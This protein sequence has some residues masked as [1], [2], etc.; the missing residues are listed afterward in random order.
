[1]SRAG[2][3]RGES[4]TWRLDNGYNSELARVTEP[5]LP[6]EGVADRY[7]HYADDDHYGQPGDLFRLLMPGWVRT[8][9]GARMHPLR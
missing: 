9:M 5:P 8:D 7:D 4:A 6:I 3:T 1:M 2:R